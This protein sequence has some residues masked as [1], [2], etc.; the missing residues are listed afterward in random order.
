M[1]PKNHKEI[2]IFYL[3]TYNNEIKVMLARYKFEFWV[4]PGDDIYPIGT[5]HRELRDC[6][7]IYFQGDRELVYYIMAG[8]R[9]AFLE[10]GLIALLFR[11]I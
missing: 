2:R 8:L 4:L 11:I 1:L 9:D 7:T 10:D 5:F 6:G 3:G